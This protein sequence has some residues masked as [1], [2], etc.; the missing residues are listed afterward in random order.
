MTAIQVSTDPVPQAATSIRILIQDAYNQGAT[1]LYMQ[2]GRSPF[3]RVHGK[4]V[5]QDDLPILTPDRFSHYVQEV[6][7]PPQLKH[8]LEAQKLDTNVKIPG[9]M[10]GRVNCGPTTQGVQA[11]SLSAIVLDQPSSEIEQQGTIRGMVE[12]ACNKGASDIHLQVGEVP[13][14]RIQGHIRLQEKYGM[15]T[16]R[17]FEEFLEEVLSPE[18]KDNFRSRQELDTAVFYKGLVRCRVNCAQSIMGGVMVLRLISLEVPTVSK[19]GLPDVLRRLAEERQGL[20]L[21]TGPVNSGKSTTLAAMLRHVNDTLPRKIVTIEDPIE[22]VH[23]SN[24]CLITQREVGLHTQEFKEAL[25]A[26][27]R[28]DPDIILIGEMRDRETI[29]TA[30][31]AALTGH[32]V[33]GTLHTKGTVNALKRLLNFYTPDEQE[34]VRLQIVEAMQA[35]IGQALVPTVKGGRTA[36]MEIMLNTDTIR[37][38]LQ[39]GCIDEIYQL[40]EEGKDGSQTLNQALFDLYE[41]GVVAQSDAVAVS[42]NPEDLNYMMKNYTRRSSRSGLMTTEYFNKPAT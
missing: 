5:P 14:Y 21:V 32:L 11:M 38:Y 12:D 35:V 10:Q 29:D 34:I 13:R 7:T 31:R 2:I 17:Q 9:F 6:L 18:Q 27:L 3:F 22:Y 8:Y 36:A 25:R 1:A 19:M 30:I 33:L 28:Q 42:L 20:I 26:A 39:K 4:L 40:M 37:D 24:Q 41:A 23:T 16:P 15:I